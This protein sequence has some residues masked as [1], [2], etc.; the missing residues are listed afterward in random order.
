MNENR[1]HPRLRTLK[2]GLIIFGTAAA[3]DCVIRN[4]SETGALL[5]VNPFGIPDE[6]TLVIK[7]EMRKRACQVAWRSVEKMG[8]RFV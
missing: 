4:M 2:G 5:A 1:A 7:P 8:V 6:F 3:I